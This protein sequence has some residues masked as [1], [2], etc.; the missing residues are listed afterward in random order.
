[1][2]TD[3]A[4]ADSKALYKKA[5][6]WEYNNLFFFD[7]LEC[8]RY[9]S[10]YPGLGDIAYHFMDS[11]FVQSKWYEDTEISIAELYRRRAEQLRDKYDHLI[12]SFSGGSDSTNIL[13]SFINNGI[14]LDEV[15]CEYPIKPLSTIQ[16]PPTN[17]VKSVAYEWFTAAKPALDSLK[18]TNPNTLITVDDTSEEAVNTV[19]SGNLHSLLR[20]GCLLNLNAVKYKKLYELARQREVRG[21]VGILFGLDKPQLR[22]DTKANKFYVHFGDFSNAYSETPFEES[23]VYGD[24]TNIEMF[25][26]SPDMPEITK[27]QSYLLK[28]AIIKLLSTAEGKSLYY[29]LLSKISVDGHHVYNIHTNFF[30]T[31]LYPTWDTKIWQ[32]PK[33]SN[34]FY[35]PQMQWFFD[36]DLTTTKQKEY[37]DKQILESLYAVDKKY[38]VLEEGKPAHL[39]HFASTPIYL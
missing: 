11:V 27:K 3:K 15:Y 20:S 32:A 5:G 39:Q 37:L 36:S 29:K 22:F 18:I 10:K 34:L 2:I 9:A 33:D 14:H 38:I 19:I 7:K 16:A 25:Y 17:S 30:K 24:N 23:Q 12:L 8:L 31:V 4:I 21:K 35:N 13:H 26:I 28:N 6:Y 1:M